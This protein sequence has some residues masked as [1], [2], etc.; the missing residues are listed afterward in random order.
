MITIA[1]LIAAGCFRKNWATE[2]MTRRRCWLTEFA[3]VAACSILCPYHLR[4]VSGK[5]PGNAQGNPGQF[6]EKCRTIYF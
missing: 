3:F 5:F 2:K 6:P 4:T 1:G